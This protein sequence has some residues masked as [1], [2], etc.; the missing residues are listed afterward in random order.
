MPKEQSTDSSACDPSKFSDQIKY[1]REE[2]TTKKSII[3]NLLENQKN[4]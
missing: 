2:N 3:Q 4:L 1:L